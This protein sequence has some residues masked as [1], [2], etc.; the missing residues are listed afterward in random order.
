[1]TDVPPPPA[2]AAQVF[3][4]QLSRACAYAELLC[5]E[6]IVRG[7]IGPREAARIWP[8]HLLN[9]AALSSLVPP[10]AHVVD[11]GSGAGL[12][13][14][15]LALARRDLDVT[16]VEPLARRVAFLEDVVAALG[17]GVRIIRERAEKLDR[18]RADV[19]TARAVAPLDRL[20]GV[21]APLLRRPGGLLLAVKGASAEDEL[22]AAKSALRPAGIVEA[23]VVRI[24]VP[25]DDR[26]TVIRCV[27][28][29][30]PVRSPRRVRGREEQGA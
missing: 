13:G 6:G 30:E 12:P 1:M 29:P 25:D 10:R 26:L 15:P 19:V 4:D 8:R 5:T 14:I 24:D 9:S 18:A 7:V 17:V 3:G 11:V 20:V 27:A 21:T 16:L 23:E 22:V 28:G 2:S